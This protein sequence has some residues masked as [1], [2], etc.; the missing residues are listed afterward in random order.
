MANISYSFYEAIKPP[1]TETLAVAYLQPLVDPLRVVTRLPPQDAKLDMPKH[2]SFLRVE[3]AGG[4]GNSMSGI[5]TVH[6][7]LHSYASYNHE[8]VCEDNMATAIAW[9]GNALG[10]T[11]ETNDGNQWY[12]IDSNVTA[13]MHHLADPRLPMV[14]YRSTIMWAVQGIAL[15]PINAGGVRQKYV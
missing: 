13:N 11:V 6:I 9:M 7:M 15:A 3:S 5:Y 8:V 10:T 1:P 4:A 2:D 14:R 12:I